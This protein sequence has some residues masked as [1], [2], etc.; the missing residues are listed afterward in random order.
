MTRNITTLEYV[1][2]EIKGVKL[3]L[4]SE[5]IFIYKDKEYK[6]IKLGNI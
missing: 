3:T 1:T 5:N 6:I 4:Q 2:L